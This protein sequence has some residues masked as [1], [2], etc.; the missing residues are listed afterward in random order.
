MQKIKNSKV[1]VLREVPM[2]FFDSLLIPKQFG[3]PPKP[4]ADWFYSIDVLLNEENFKIM[5]AKV[6]DYLGSVGLSIK[7]MRSLSLKKEPSHEN[8]G[9]SSV[10]SFKNYPIKGIT[11]QDKARRHKV[12]HAAN[13]SP[14]KPEELEGFQKAIV[15]I[16]GCFCVKRYEGSKILGTY[17]NHVQIIQLTER[18]TPPEVE[19]LAPVQA[20]IDTAEEQGSQQPE[21]LAS[22]FKAS[23]EEDGDFLDDF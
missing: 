11:D 23:E 22:G 19:L 17:M 12:T 15:N 10:L 13:N 7:K 8:H 9:E 2:V 18:Y 6:K 20:P 4:D 5:A 3:N 1:F 16:S 14:V 21:L